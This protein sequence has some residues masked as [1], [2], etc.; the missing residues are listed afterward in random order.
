MGNQ[1]SG[2]LFK[3]KN[4]K[5]LQMTVNQIAKKYILSQTFKDMEA[6]GKNLKDTN[7]SCDKITIFTKDILNEYLNDRQVEY[8][9]QQTHDGKEVNVIQD[10]K[11]I[12]IHDDSIKKVKDKKS[13]LTKK[14]MCIG[15]AKYYVDIAR[16]FAAIS[17]TVNIDFTYTTISGEVEEKPFYENSDDLKDSTLSSKKQYTN[18]CE[19][20]IKNVLNVIVR[21]NN[22][23]NTNM[24][25]TGGDKSDVVR[26]KVG[27]CENKNI[28][29]LDKNIENGIKELDALYYDRYN[30]SDGTYTERS[31]KQDKKYKEDVKKIYT[32]FYNNRSPDKSISSFSDIKM[33]TFS[34]GKCN[35]N[36]SIEVS[37][38]DKKYKLFVKSIST[39]Y[40]EQHK[41]KD[42]LLTILFNIFAK[43]STRDGKE[44]IIL[45]PQLNENRLQEIKQETQMQILQYYMHCEK[46][47]QNILEVYEAL[48]IHIGV[49]TIGAREREREAREFRESSFDEW[50]E[51]KDKKEK[52][53]KVEEIVE[54]GIHPAA[55]KKDHEKYPTTGK[56]HPAAIPTDSS[57]STA[58]SSTS[59][60][61]KCKNN[62]K[63]QYHQDK[64]QEDTEEKYKYSGYY[65]INNA[66]QYNAIYYYNFMINQ[67]IWSEEKPNG[68][69]IELQHFLN[70]KQTEARDIEKDDGKYLLYYANTLEKRKRAY[71]SDDLKQRIGSADVNNYTS[72]K[73]PKFMIELLLKEILQTSGCY[74]GG[75]K[76]FDEN[77]A[78]ELENK[79]DKIKGIVVCKDEVNYYYYALKP[80]SKKEKELCGQYTYILFDSKNN[81]KILLTNTDLKCTYMEKNEIMDQYSYA[82]DEG[83]L[84]QMKSRLDVLHPK[85]FKKEHLIIYEKNNYLGLPP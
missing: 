9:H 72:S 11:L 74:I 73:T 4:H 14:R 32:L 60:S 13:K 43:R 42:G 39:Y 16:I 79:P 36:E 83:K 17:K 76:K 58:K 15:I 37:T 6:L 53:D 40:D 80:L 63:I 70:E 23:I 61:S 44:E 31:P 27:L 78:H 46:H 81:E 2:S 59:N 1:N 26:I 28:H 57:S 62:Y 34:K 48:L 68:K 5:E 52:V 24:N 66:L 10:D 75:F 38:N 50:T 77:T 20:R 41:L 30:Y 12:Y 67:D 22:K 25:Q 82:G 7:S 54:E 55:I 21:E 71:I 29:F 33:P 19:R 49:V 18:F 8:L 65:A 56:I 64:E 69:N 51:K 35:S 45:H 47:Y 3:N 85:L 84:K